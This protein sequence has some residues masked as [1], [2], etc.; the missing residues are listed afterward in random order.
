MWLPSLRP[1]P[2]PDGSQYTPS[3]WGCSSE[4]LSSVFPP[5]CTFLV[6]PVL[7]SSGAHFH[8]EHS[9]LWRGCRPWSQEAHSQWRGWRPFLFPH[10]KLLPCLLP[11]PPPFSFLLEFILW[12]SN[13]FRTLV[14]WNW[15]WNPTKRGWSKQLNMSDIVSRW[16]QMVAPQMDR[17]LTPNRQPVQGAWEC[18]GRWLECGSGGLDGSW[19][20]HSPHPSG[21]LPRHRLR[22]Q[23]VL[24]AA[25][26]LHSI[27]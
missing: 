9:F 4:S 22:S 24:S 27:L 7:P 23:V 10:P 13:G 19:L 17:G 15:A 8:E 26:C 14:C 20:G 3:S 6:D 25:L 18:S 5:G 21:E 2:E 12:F 16:I 1:L 11:G